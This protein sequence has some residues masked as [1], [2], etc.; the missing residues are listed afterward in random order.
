MSGFDFELLEIRQIETNNLRL[1]SVD[2]SLLQQLSEDGRRPNNMLASKAGVAPSTALARVRRLED[3]GVIKG[4]HADLDLS[5]LGFGIQA[6]LFL[7]V[8]AHARTKM[9]AVARRLRME[10]QVQQVFVV[11]GDRDLV[12]NVICKSTADL[13]DFLNDKIGSDPDLGSSSTSLVLEA[14]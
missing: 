2:I 5:L 6:L 9:L 14:L 10:P 11:G 12:V 13:R 7:Q 8:Q 3:L 1:D 4:Y